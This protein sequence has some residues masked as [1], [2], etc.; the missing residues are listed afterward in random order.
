MIVMPARSSRQLWT[1]PGDD[2]TAAEGINASPAA[3]NIEQLQAADA[4]GQC[5][6]DNQIVADWLQTEHRPEQ[7]QWCPGRPRLRAA[8]GGILHRILRYCSGI[9]TES[10]REPSV[11]KLCRLQNPRRDD[12]RLILEAVTAK[13]PGYEGVVEWPDGSHVIA[14]RVVAAFTGRH[15][16]D[17]PAGEQALTQQ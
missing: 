8:G 7:Q 17:P 15:G 16:A 10:F 12:G 11:E 6:I 5:G 1:L 13:T 2:P 14:D 3:G 9:A 4:H